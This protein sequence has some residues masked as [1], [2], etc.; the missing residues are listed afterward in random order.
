MKRICIFSFFDNDGI[1]DE[2]IEYYLNEISQIV[3][4]IVIVVNGNIKNDYYKK[5]LKY[6]DEIIVRENKGY[7][8][9]AYKQ[10]MFD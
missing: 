3:K 10:C 7:D 2:Y 6:T 5:L 8:A 1:V 4:R 9:G